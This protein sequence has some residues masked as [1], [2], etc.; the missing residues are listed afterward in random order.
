MIQN[1]RLKNA[2]PPSAGSFWT[3]TIYQ[4]YQSPLQ[5]LL[6][7]SP[8]LLQGESNEDYYIRWWDPSYRFPVAI[9]AL[10]FTKQYHILRHEKRTSLSVFRIYHCMTFPGCHAKA[11]FSSLLTEFSL[12]YMCTQSAFCIWFLYPHVVCS[13]HFVCVPSPFPFT[14]AMQLGPSL[15]VCSFD[16]DLG[17][18]RLSQL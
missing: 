9:S 1:T 10:C 18:K 8:T 13:L 16:I 2:L 15:Q 3:K 11:H 14:P 12:V 6:G 5:P 7:L 4:L 17:L